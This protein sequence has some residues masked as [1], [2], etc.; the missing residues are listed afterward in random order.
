MIPSELSGSWFSQSPAWRA[1]A[2]PL[3]LS[4]FCLI[5]PHQ[6]HHVPGMVE[7]RFHQ[8]VGE[9]SLC[10]FCNSGRSI[11]TGPDPAEMAFSFPGKVP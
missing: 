3:W 5:E 9:V 8:E 2:S 4:S 1:S 6:S 11:Q 7:D 10:K